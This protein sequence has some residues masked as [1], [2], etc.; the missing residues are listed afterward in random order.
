MTLSS[1]LA[2]LPTCLAQTNPIKPTFTI[3]TIDDT[4]YFKVKNQSFTSHTDSNGYTIY[5]FYEYHFKIHGVDDSYAWQS[6]QRTWEQS[7][8]EYTLV[9][10]NGWAFQ[11]DQYD[12]QIRALIGTH[13]VRSPMYGQSEPMFEGVY[14]DWS[15]I[16]TVTLNSSAST[17]A[18]SPL[19]NTSPT[20]PESSAPNQTN[21]GNTI[22]DVATWI[23][24]A[25]V[26]LLSA[27]VTLLIT[28]V[29]YL[30]KKNRVFHQQHHTNTQ[31]KHKTQRKQKHTPIKNAMFH[32]PNVTSMKIFIRFCVSSSIDRVDGEL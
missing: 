1:F 19:P 25:L 14:S 30:H 28:I 31:H 9:P 22:F 13:T 3:H 12:I 20:T 8:T 11:S 2:F 7:E 10:F 18:S 16:Q 4:I 24:I 17:S 27:I 29:V 15:N 26:V 23:G 5:L 32:N 21:Y 6:S